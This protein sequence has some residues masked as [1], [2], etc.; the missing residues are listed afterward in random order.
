MAAMA[1]AKA[2]NFIESRARVLLLLYR[3]E[4]ERGSVYIN[5]L[6]ASGNLIFLDAVN[7]RISIMQ[8]AAFVS[9]KQSFKEH[10]GPSIMSIC[11]T[12]PE[13]GSWRKHMQ[14]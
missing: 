2:V 8:Y 5:F 13:R 6:P 11:K 14:P 9:K 1:R 4:H 12:P 3:D 10:A 7:V